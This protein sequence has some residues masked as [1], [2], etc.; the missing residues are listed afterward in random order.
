M[1]IHL[2]WA[3]DKYGGIGKNGKLPWHISEDLKHF[4]TLTLN[5]TI[6]MGRKTWDSLPI[7]P[8][9]NRTNIILS[10]TQQNKNTY[11][12]FEQ[13][14][15]KLKEQ[16]TKK[17]FV[18]GGRTIYKLFFNYADYLHIT[19][20]QIIKEGINE[21][22]PIKNNEIELKF[23]LKN[24]HKLCEDAIYTYWEKI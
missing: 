22:F 7:K 19:N 14:F 15:N 16:N 3:Q 1:D 24:T 18:I 11:N 2:I 5:S 8:L 6:V 12:S 13:C 9:P 17:I 20:I 21:F 23:K 10:K 4:K